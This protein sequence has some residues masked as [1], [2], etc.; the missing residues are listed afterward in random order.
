MRKDGKRKRQRREERRT[1]SKV[2]VE[3]GQ[4]PEDGCPQMGSVQAQKYFLQTLNPPVKEI[5]DV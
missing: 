4:L 5:E 3:S 2:P 1:P